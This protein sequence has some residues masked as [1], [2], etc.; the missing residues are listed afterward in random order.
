MKTTGTYCRA[1]DEFDLQGEIDIHLKD[2]K[3]KLGDIDDYNTASDI[4]EIKKAMIEL[5]LEQL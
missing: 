3:M 4:K 5:I 2:L 1:E